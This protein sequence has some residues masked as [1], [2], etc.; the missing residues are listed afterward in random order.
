M[1]KSL[2]TLPEPVQQ[3]DELNEEEFEMEYE[4]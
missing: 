2:A 3:T 1:S 4:G